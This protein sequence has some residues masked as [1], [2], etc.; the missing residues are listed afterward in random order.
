MNLVILLGAGF[1]RNWG[2][3]LAKEAFEYLLGCDEIVNCSRLR[4]LLWEHQS[5]GGFEDAL[6]DLQR[7]YQHDPE[8]HGAD[9]QAF[10]TAVGRM[11]EE[12]NSGYATYAGWEFQPQQRFM[13]RTFLN[14]FEAIFSLNQDLRK[15]S[16]FHALPPVREFC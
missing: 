10:Q 13:V 14:Q 4:Q 8:K 6:A 3:W 16:I 12:M 1:S 15:R 7:N 11:F 9:L 5:A 2:G